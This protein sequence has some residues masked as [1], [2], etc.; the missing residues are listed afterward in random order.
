MLS[1]FI[2]SGAAA[3]IPYPYLL[4]YLCDTYD[5][6]WTFLIAGSLMMVSTLLAF[7]W[8]LTPSLEDKVKHNVTDTS[9]ENTGSGSQRDVNKQ[10]SDN[11]ELPQQSNET[12]VRNHPI[13]VNE[14]EEFKESKPDEE[15][16]W[17]T[18]LIALLK[19]GPFIFFV[20][21]QSLSHES[22]IALSI[23]VTD[24]LKD[25]GVDTYKA[26]AAFMAFNFGSLPGLLL[27]GIFEKLPRAN[28]LFAVIVTTLL[29][30]PAVIALN[31]I[32]APGLAITACIICG[33]AFGALSSS[34]V[35]DVANF[36]RTEHYTAAVGMI[37]G[38]TGI[39]L[40]IT[41]PL[42]G[43]LKVNHSFK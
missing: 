24:I 38:L 1:V 13:S 8:I 4:R 23:F 14:L 40:S 18:I 12:Q 19:N 26:T 25:R 5:L 30:T 11:T 28:S 42:G 10:T 29:A 27:P 6:F 31:F 7:T 20:I 3:A 35:V 16:S 34:S 33:I 17:K 37:L 9:D 22:L 41:G 39:L 15:D 32:L 2:T 36:V 43:E 21:G